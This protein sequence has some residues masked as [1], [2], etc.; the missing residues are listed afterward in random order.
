MIFKKKSKKGTTSFLLRF[1]MMVHLLRF[2][3]DDV[4]LE[5]NNIILLKF[6]LDSPPPPPNEN[7]TLTQHLQCH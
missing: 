6:E 4:N 3:K 1:E 2:E 7:I 5:I